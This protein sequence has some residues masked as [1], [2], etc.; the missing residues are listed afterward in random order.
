VGESLF[1]PLTVAENL[2]LALSPDQRTHRGLRL[3]RR[4]ADALDF[5]RGRFPGLLEFS[6]SLVSELSGGWRAVLALAMALRRRPRLLLLDEVAAALDEQNSALFWQA[7][8]EWAGLDA[9][10]RPAVIFVSHQ[11]LTARKYA[12]RAV[13]MRDGIVAGEI[14]GPALAA[15][16]DRGFVDAYR[17]K[18]W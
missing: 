3:S 14:N 8:R 13:F 11:V 1:S 15:L 9:N 16:D 4:T 7:L 10:E 5:A 6:G 12:C 2:V 18:C 17:E